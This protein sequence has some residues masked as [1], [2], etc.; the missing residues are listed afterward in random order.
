[1]YVF[2]KLR[3][4]S[5]S[6]RL[7]AY[8]KYEGAFH[9][10]ALSDSAVL[11]WY[12]RTPGGRCHIALD[13]N[14]KL[15][16]AELAV[17]LRKYY[18]YKLSFQ[19]GILISIFLLWSTQRWTHSVCTHLKPQ[20]TL[21]YSLLVLVCLSLPIKVHLQIPASHYMTG[22]HRYEKGPDWFPVMNNA[23]PPSPYVPSSLTFPFP[24]D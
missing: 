7:S 11:L 24:T 10:T 1:M 9:F 6:W 12:S 20:Q 23:T 19:N 5:T 13:G 8:V 22:H 4:Y 2:L 21:F 16:G 3:N 15:E 14:Q 18:G 17:L